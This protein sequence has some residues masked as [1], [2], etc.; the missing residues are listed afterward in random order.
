VWVAPALTRQWDDRQKARELRLAI[1][2]EAIA[3]GTQMIY[4]A[5][6]PPRPGFKPAANYDAL[7]R[8]WSEDSALLRAKL[9]A[10]YPHEVEK[11]RLA[12]G[13]ASAYLFFHQGGP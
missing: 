6:K 11:R 10:Y 13:R 7:S 4:A 9:R 12:D 3:K 5:S 8:Q 1:T 2:Q